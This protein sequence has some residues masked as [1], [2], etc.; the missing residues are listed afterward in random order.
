MLPAAKKPEATVKRMAVGDC[1]LTEGELE[2]REL[3]V[4]RCPEVRVDRAIG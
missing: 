3:D 1:G 4:E 2:V